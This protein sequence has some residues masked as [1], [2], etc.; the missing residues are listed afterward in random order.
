M[1]P[2]TADCC[3]RV[4][5]HWNALDGVVVAVL[6]WWHFVGAN[7]SDDG[8]ILTMARVSENAGYMAN[9]YRWFGTPEAPFGVVLRPLGVMGTS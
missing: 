6:V 5:G 1:E 7:T 4:G 9:Y 2:D 8:Y 3:L